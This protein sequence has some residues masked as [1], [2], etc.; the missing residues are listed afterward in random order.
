MAN[1]DSRQRPTAILGADI[2]DYCRLLSHDRVSTIRTLNTR[3][4][5]FAGF[6]KLYSGRVVDT[7]SENVLAVMESVSVSCRA[8]E[9]TG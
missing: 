5:M 9:R 4:E 1:E 8:T 3:R 7:P 6:V 2:T